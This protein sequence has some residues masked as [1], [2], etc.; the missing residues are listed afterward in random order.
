MP[1]DERDKRYRFATRLIH[2]R[3]R[4]ERWDYDHHVIPPI[5]ASTA[6]RLE[7]ADRGR[8][9]FVDFAAPKAAAQV[10]SAIYLRPT[11]R[12]HGRHAGRNDEGRRT[13]GERVRVRLWYVRHIRRHPGNDE[14]GQQYRGPSHPVWMHLQ[15][16]HPYS[17]TLAVSLGM[18]K[19]L[20]ETPGLMTH[21][22]MEPEALFE[23]GIHPGGVRLA[24]GLEEPDDIITDLDAALAHI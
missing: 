6:F 14:G 16:A 24:I 12:A 5:T 10:L 1:D 11:G 8:R 17:V 22:A 15:P 2:G 19:T 9:G 21:S 20:V 7:S 18:T 23:A 3:F 13:G 4:T